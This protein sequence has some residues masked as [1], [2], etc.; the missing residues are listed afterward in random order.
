MVAGIR[1]ARCA[2][3]FL[4]VSFSTLACSDSTLTDREK[5]QVIDGA[6]SRVRET[7]FETGDIQS[8]E[9]AIRG[10]VAQGAYR[11]STGPEAFANQLQ[12]DFR[13]ASKDPHFRVIYVPGEMPRLPT[14]MKRPPETD[15][16]RAARVHVEAVL[17]N[18]G[19]ARVQRLEGNVGVLELTNLPDGEN[20]VEKAAAAMTFLKDTSA[21]ILDLR[22]NGG[23]EITGVDVVLSYFVEG[24]IHTYDMLARKPEDNLQYFTDA[25]VAGPRYAA[26]K[27]VFVLTSRRTFSAGEAMVDAMRTWRHAR[28]VGERTRGGSN[29]A[30]PTKATDHFIVGVPFMKTVNVATGKNWNVVGI[31][32][33]VAVLAD[34]AQDAAYLLA[35]ESIAAATPSAAF[36]EQVQ[37]II[38]KLKSKP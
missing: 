26:E 11:A 35:L 14:S 12:D 15:A 18:N 10:K 27:S 1:R 38:Q 33:D 9:A 37:A 8:I 16:D 36:R 32:P 3:A 23:G 31:E 22:A 6:L 25:S 29:A 2:F 19:F 13:D 20:M 17:Y 24:R 5:A 28:I 30:L 7:Y 4:L 21:F 34:K